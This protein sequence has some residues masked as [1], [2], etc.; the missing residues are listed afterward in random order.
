MSIITFR[1][2]QIQREEGHGHSD[3][4]IPCPAGPRPRFKS[5]LWIREG[6]ECQSQDF[7]L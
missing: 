5:C 3:L 4:P 1:R 6:I 2:K 7:G